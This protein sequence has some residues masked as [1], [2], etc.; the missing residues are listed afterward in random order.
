VRDARIRAPELVSSLGVTVATVLPA[1]LAGAMSAMIIADAGIDHVMFGI[2][3]SAFFVT[4]A[5]L[6][7]WAGR[8]VDRLGAA[9]GVR[10]A[11]ALSAVSMLGVV[12]LGTSYPALVAFLLV[13]GAGAAM[14]GPVGSILL[15]DAAGPRWQAFLFGVRQAFV[16]AASVIGG[17]AVS[18][19]AGTP[20][21]WR[22]TFLV[23]GVLVVVL[24]FPFRLRG[25][26][27]AFRAHAPVFPAYRLHELWL[28]AAAF[29][30]A[31]CAATAVTTFI[32]DYAALSG[33]SPAFAG[34][35]LALASCAAVVARVMTGYGV[36]R[37]RLDSLAVIGGLLVCGVL[38]FAWLAVGSDAA[39][40]PGSVIGMA[41]AWG[42]GGVLVY[43]VTFGFGASPGR[44]NGIVLAGGATGGILGPVVIGWV[45]QTFSYEAAWATSAGFVAASAAIVAYMLVRRR[46]AVASTRG[47][48]R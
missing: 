42:W 24:A 48:P 12:L 15:A 10:L 16:P 7:P 37:W 22:L 3:V 25:R 18:L 33:Q 38:G 28:L 6:S 30:L 39:I 20:S 19:V 45:V 29:A 41:G 8:L 11:V 46:L 43:S 35:A 1:S 32:V 21:G 2:A 4:N 44:A 5:G 14:G 34:V 27:D 13:G 17:I 23:A 47:G 36:S 31:G 40:V 9:W 26:R